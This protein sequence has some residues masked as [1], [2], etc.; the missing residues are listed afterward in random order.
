MEDPLPT[1]PEPATAR[2]A[3][4][5]HS[6][7]VVNADGQLTSREPERVNNGSLLQ[8][9]SFSS[10]RTWFFSNL[11]FMGTLLWGQE[12]GAPP[13]KVTNFEIRTQSLTRAA[14]ATSRGGIVRAQNPEDGGAHTARSGGALTA[15]STCNSARSQGFGMSTARSAASNGAVDL[16]GSARESPVSAG[17]YAK[18]QRSL[19]NRATVEQA[20]ADRST[21][22]EVR[23]EKARQQYEASQEKRERMRSVNDRVQRALIRRNLEQGRQVRQESIDNAHKIERIREE[24]HAVVRAQVEKDKGGYD[25]KDA[26]LDVQEEAAAAALREEHVREKLAFAESVQEFRQR[27]TEERHQAAELLKQT[28]NAKLTKALQLSHRR[29]AKDAA[30][31]RADTEREMSRKAQLGE[32]FM[33]MQK[34]KRERVAKMKQEAGQSREQLTKQRRRRIAQLRRDTQA[35]IE[36]NERLTLS[37][38]QS[39]RNKIFSAHFV[40]REAAVKF[41]GSEF[42]KLYSMD[43][44]ADS[45]I[46]AE[47]AEILKKIASVTQ[48]TDDDVADEAAGEARIQAAADSKARKEAERKRIARENAERAHRIRNVTAV[49]DNVLDTEASA[50]RR[51]EMAIE[52]KERRKAE[53]AALAQANLE[54]YKRLKSVKAATDDDVTDEALG[55]ARRQAAAAS[56]KRKQEEAE[57]LARE[58]AE[59]AHGLNSAKAAT[60]TDITDEEAGRQRNVM[61]SES[62]ERKAAEASKLDSQNAQMKSTLK[63][64]KAKVDDDIDD[65]AAGLAR[66]GYDIHHRNISQQL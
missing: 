26:R 28:T 53:A 63:K 48:R 19:E 44:L 15:R 50:A 49:T 22:D 27:T 51:K 40:K 17:V 9:I 5:S 60:D 41:D 13:E 21:R 11:T 34:E 32:E 36:E 55:E 42:R 37:S 54:I 24:H 59:F 38:R 16:L 3:S 31:L 66:K 65:D 6:K 14:Y 58:N 7:M 2:T 56:R 35:E 64:V 8:A 43:D 57:R 20:H 33:A 45:Q 25:S 30:Q 46:D 18:Y 62:K 10:T 47:N 4:G 23:Q 29:K 39:V 52:S 12:H 61:A 1:D